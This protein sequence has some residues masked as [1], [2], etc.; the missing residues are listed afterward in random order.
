MGNWVNHDIRAF[1]VSK[2]VDND[3]LVTDH[4]PG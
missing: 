3:L 2:T 1:H 4:C